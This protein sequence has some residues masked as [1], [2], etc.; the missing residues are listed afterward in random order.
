MIRRKLHSERGA[1]MVLA[2]GVFI[3][4]TMI[5]MVIV[6]A[7]YSNARKLNS[8]KEKQ[9]AYYAVKSAVGM[10]QD[11]V[12]GDTIKETVDVVEI[13]GE[14]KEQDDTRVIKYNDYG[15]LEEPLP[16][17]AEAPVYDDKYVQANLMKNAVVKL[18]YGQ[19]KTGAGVPES[20][21]KQSFTIA[22]A[23]GEPSV[24]VVLTMEDY[25]IFA[26][27]TAVNGSEELY[28]MVVSF[29]KEEVTDTVADVDKEIRTTEYTYTE[30]KVSIDRS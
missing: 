22:G 5:S 24:K 30:D 13:D 11:F 16:E 2:L 26:E 28:S 25:N 20:D 3:V 12:V 1:S 9:Q 15:F 6:S 10:L 14:D 8:R 29:S 21:K 18:A 19:F 17:G 7:A 23:A 27:C 4:A